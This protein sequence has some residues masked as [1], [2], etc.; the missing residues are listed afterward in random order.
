MRFAHFIWDF[1]GTLFDSYPRIT[2]AFIKALNGLGIEA[3]YGET[4][5]L[6]KVTLRRAAEVLAP[7]SDYEEVL[8]LYRRHAEEEGPETLRLYPGAAEMLSAVVRAGGDNCLYTHRGENAVDALRREGVNGLFR[9]IVTLEDGF[10]LKPAP[11]ALLSL[12]NRNRFD[13]SRCLMLGDRD[14]DM[15]A[16]RNAGVAAA[17][18]DPEGHCG[19]CAAD[20]RFTNFLDMRKVLVPESALE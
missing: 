7:G 19:G 9:D 8:T 20:F 11:D 16:G 3:G 15:E 12:I 4:L 10:P 2:R 5:A 17:L 13:P 1:D 6:L 14:I 18:F